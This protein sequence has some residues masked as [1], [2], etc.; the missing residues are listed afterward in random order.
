MLTIVYANKMKR[1]VKRIKRRG[2]DI[3]KLIVAL[4]L[5]AA[6]ESMPEK[7]NDHPLKGKLKR[8]VLQITCRLLI[9]IDPV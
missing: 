2:K 3:S 6:G 5:L 4:D 8:F 9:R 7:Y 1:D